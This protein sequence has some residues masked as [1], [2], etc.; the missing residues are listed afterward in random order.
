MRKTNSARLALAIALALGAAAAV[1]PAAAGPGP[2]HVVTTTAGLGA[3]AREVGGDRVEVTHLCQGYQDPHYLT[4][5]PSLARA[6]NRADLLVYNGLEL[7]IGWLPPLVDSARNPRIRAGS[8]GD[9]DASAA[10]DVLD[11]PTGPVDRSSGD[12][13]PLGNPHYLL[14]PRNGVK[15]AELLAR[16]LGELDPAHAAEYTDRYRTFA[17]RMDE[18]TRRWEERASPLR[19]ATIV[20]YHQQWEYLARWLG[21]RIAGYVE[22]R[23]GISPAPR[24]LDELGRAARESHIAA[25]LAANFNDLRPAEKVCQESGAALLVLPADV[26]GEESIATYEAHFDRLVDGLLAC[27]R[28]PQ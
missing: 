19:G 16:R 7:E 6:L 20:A 12:I 15:V 4:A 2:F 28:P 18:A 17:A 9:L 8:A 11:R 13:H 24:H 5:K 1:R 27:A 25:L 10:I 21:I 22:N 23:P 14:D 26:E 3:L